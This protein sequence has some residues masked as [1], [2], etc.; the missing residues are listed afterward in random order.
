MGRD[1]EPPGLRQVSGWCA[2]LVPCCSPWP[3]RSTRRRARSCPTPSST[4][5]LTLGLPGR[6]LHLWDPQGAFGQLQNQAYGYLLPMGPFHWLLDLGGRAWLG[7]PAAVVVADPVCGLPRRL[8]ALRALSATARPG[9]ASLVALLYALSPRMLGEVAITSI[10][11]WPLAMAPWVLLPLVTPKARSWLVADQLL[12]PG[13]RT[14][15]AESTRSRP[16]QRWCCPPCGCSPRGWTS[17]R[18]RRG[19]LVRLRGR[20]SRSGGWCRL[21][22]LGRYSPPFLDWIENACGHDRVRPASSSP[23]AG[24]RVVELPCR[25]VPGRA[26]RPAG[27]SSRQP[28]LIMSRPWLRRAAGPAACDGLRE[29]AASSSSRCSSAW[30]LLTLG[31]PGQRSS[32]LAHPA[33]GPARRSLWRPCGT[34]TSSSWC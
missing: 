21:V 5:P 31:P 15:S 19:R 3:W 34:P 8:E 26:G 33:A 12:G 17:R 30:S 23:S 28:A 20:A 4:S 9:P 27:C 25:Q 7:D 24:R 10:E 13:V 18:S 1:S 29:T 32:P 22:L 14:W 11:V 16:E 6:A 2:R